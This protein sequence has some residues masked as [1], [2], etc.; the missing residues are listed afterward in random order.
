MPL[1]HAVTGTDRLLGTRRGRSACVTP[2]DPDE[3]AGLFGGGVSLCGFFP[4]SQ[5]H[6]NLRDCSSQSECTNAPQQ[7]VMEV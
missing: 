3:A 5:E 2:A 1:P 7:E 4:L 6:E